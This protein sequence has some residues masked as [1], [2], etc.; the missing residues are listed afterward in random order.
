MDL[1]SFFKRK[2]EILSWTLEHERLQNKFL[3]KWDKNYYNFVR[4]FVD[5]DY[6]ELCSRKLHRNRTSFVANQISLLE[7]GDVFTFQW[8]RNEFCLE[9]ILLLEFEK[10]HYPDVYLRERL[11]AAIHVPETRFVFRKSLFCKISIMFYARIS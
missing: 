11:A 9:W 6:D 5:E 3:G 10:T 4:Q 2:L 1:T 7:K 8:S